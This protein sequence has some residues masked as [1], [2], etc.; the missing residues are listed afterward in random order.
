M[1]TKIKTKGGN[2]NMNPVNFERFNDK[3]K[4]TWRSRFNQMRWALCRRYKLVMPTDEIDFIANEY[5][6]K[7]L[8]PQAV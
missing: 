6:D 7:V 8:T 2:K 5:A 1:Q 4:S 3:Q